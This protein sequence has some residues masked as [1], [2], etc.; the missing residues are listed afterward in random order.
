VRG[1]VPDPDAPVTVNCGH[2]EHEG[3][4]VEADLAGEAPSKC[5]RSHQEATYSDANT[6]AE[7]GAAGDTVVLK[8]Q[9]FSHGGYELQDA[10]KAPE[11]DEREVDDQ[12]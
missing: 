4:Q 3:E 11:D 9:A 5:T 7:E 8:R 10:Q 1:D 2:Q 6:K 12:A